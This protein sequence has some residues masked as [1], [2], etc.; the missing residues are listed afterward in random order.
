V[1]LN[2]DDVR[3]G[4]F[5]KCLH[6]FPNAQSCLKLAWLSDWTHDCRVRQISSSKGGILLL[7]DTNAT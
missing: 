5:E 2:F 7:V 4:K 6:S 3:K 1:S